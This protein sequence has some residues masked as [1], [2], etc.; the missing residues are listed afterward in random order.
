[1]TCGNGLFPFLMCFQYD[2]IQFANVNITEYGGWNMYAACCDLKSCRV[3]R[4]ISYQIPAFVFKA[5]VF[6]FRNS[7]IVA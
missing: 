3:A 4:G 2:T 5:V 1:M 6:N 7:P